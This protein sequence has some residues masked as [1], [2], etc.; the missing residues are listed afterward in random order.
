M[1]LVSLPSACLSVRLLSHD[2]E[3]AREE[4]DEDDEEEDQGLVRKEQDI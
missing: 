1:S 4:D 2:T 3:T